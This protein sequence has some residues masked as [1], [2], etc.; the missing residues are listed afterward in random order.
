M[1]QIK[2]IK[3]ALALGVALLC[4]ACSGPFSVSGQVVDQYG[5]P[6]GNVRLH[7]TAAVKTDNEFDAYGGEQSTTLS[8]G[9]FKVRCGNCSAVHLFFSK[10]GYHPQAVDLAFFEWSNDMT[11]VLYER[12]PPVDL[13]PHEAKITAGPGFDDTYMVIDGKETRV[14]TEAELAAE[15][16]ELPYIALRPAAN[17]DGSLIT[18]TPEFMPIIKYAELDF[19][20]ANGAAQLYEPREMS[21][22]YAY[23]EMSAAPVD[24]YT[25]RIRLENKLPGQLFFF[26]CIIDGYYCK[27]TATVPGLWQDEESSRVQVSIETFVNPVPSHRGLDDPRGYLR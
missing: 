20:G 4:A 16:S 26:Y 15:E 22:T 10:D 3:F 24:G 18:E 17:D 25:P 27:G 9:E 12:G 14:L 2:A 23:A 11:I 21:L 7:T 13:N 8:D 6:L 5:N 1:F 19:S